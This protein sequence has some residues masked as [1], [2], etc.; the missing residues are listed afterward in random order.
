[1]RAKINSQDNMTNKNT[2]IYTPAIAN[3]TR[4][5]K[6]AG[7]RVLIEVIN[8]RPAKKA[9]AQK[10]PYVIPATPKVSGIGWK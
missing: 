8:K 10:K 2:L 4:K 7:R 6:T 5:S 9:P 3:L 1:M